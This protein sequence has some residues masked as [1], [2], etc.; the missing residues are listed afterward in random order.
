MRQTF[1]PFGPIMEIRVFPDKGYSFIRSASCVRLLITFF[2]SSQ[3]SMIQEQTEAL[4][5]VGKLLLYQ[6]FE[7]IL[8][9]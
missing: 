2:A 3:L 9:E 4:L 6:Q 8:P 1:S 7:V 5:A